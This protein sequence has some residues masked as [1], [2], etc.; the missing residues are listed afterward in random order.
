MADR[1]PR[2]AAVSI[3][4]V[5]ELAGVS[6]ATVSKVLNGRP[7]VAAA[8]RAKVEE[9]VEQQG[10][11]RRR[12]VRSTQ[13]PLIDLVLH[14]LDSAWSIEIVTGVERV[15]TGAGIDVVLSE[16]GGAHRPSAAWLDRVLTRH[17]IGVI[18]VQADIDRT[19]RNRLQAASIPC[20]VV[21]T[22]GE[23]PVGVPTV[24]S[25]NWSGGLAATRHL[26]ALGHRR[27]AV[28]SGPTEVLC[29]RARV[30][31]YRTAH[32]EL[33][34]EVDPDLIRYGNF[35]FSGGYEHGID[36]LSRIDR[37]TAVFAGADAQALGVIRAAADLGLR[38]PDDVS[39]V[40]YDDLQL[41]EWTVPALTTVRQPLHAMAATAMDMVLELAA[42]RSPANPR[43]E[44]ATELV[45]RASTAP[46]TGG[47][48]LGAG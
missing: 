15:A 11:R 20:V 48:A 9:V 3:G 7:D 37:P 24:G 10:Y 47:A 25:G 27:V 16:L 8:T 28:V 13:P 22:A 35:V 23:P 32:S 21:D 41:A 33:G 18:L 12:A 5:A 2:P 30:D 17:P 38:V 34:L 6:V 26:L 31:G 29:S 14:E 45:V 46:W 39:V 4:R 42:G 43:I 19:Q 40:G 44:L 1:N 36:L